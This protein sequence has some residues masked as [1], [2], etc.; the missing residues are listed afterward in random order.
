MK[1]DHAAIDQRFRPQYRLRSGRD[2]QRVYRRRCV[3]SDDTLIVHSCENELGHPRLGLSVS[4][5]VGGAVVRNR[6]KRLLREAFRLRRPELPQ[7]VDLVVVPRAGVAVDLST[8][9]ESLVGVAR[10][11]ARKL[12][13]N[14]T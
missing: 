5:K 10:R 9:M 12:D 6:W 14:R 11:A 8:V 2:F 3:A 13:R 4:R 7:G 1:T